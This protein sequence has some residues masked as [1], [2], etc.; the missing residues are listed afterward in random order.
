LIAGSPGW[1]ADIGAK[2]I[3]MKGI[4]A[5]VL[6]FTLFACVI[7]GF[8][9]PANAAETE[10]TGDVAAKI[11]GTV[12]S[13]NS[14]A[15]SAMEQHLR[16][17]LEAFSEMEQGAAGGFEPPPD[18]TSKPPED[19]AQFNALKELLVKMTP[20]E[21]VKAGIWFLVI[22]PKTPRRDEITRLIDQNAGT[23]TGP[24]SADYRDYMSVRKGL[25]GASYGSR[26]ERWQEYV[27][28]KPGSAFADVAKREIQHLE[29][30]QKDKA[31]ERKS[32]ASKFFV[33][34]G[35]VLVVL[36]L[37]VVIIFGAAK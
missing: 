33:K 30:V 10:T 16:G 14:G 23:L 9:K 20:L 11:I 3:A 25:S 32:G 37:L 34:V 4:V 8:V 29:S 6:G 12:D 1:T 15:D 18:D 22:Q 31:A 26:I 28:A 21:R 17:K 19:D 7:L 13:L 2:G 27:K 36:A 35:I 5:Q 24:E